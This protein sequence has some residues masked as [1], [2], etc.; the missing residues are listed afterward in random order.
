M[1]VQ[2][3][4]LIGS[5]SHNIYFLKMQE[6][7]ISKDNKWI[8]NADPF[9]VA[10]SLEDPWATFPGDQLFLAYLKTLTSLNPKTCTLKIES[11]ADIQTV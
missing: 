1:L 2:N 11:K 3:L 10:A 4:T 5:Y 7:T 9:L 6:N 8:L